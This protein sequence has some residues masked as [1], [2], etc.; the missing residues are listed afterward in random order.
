MID[1]KEC[2]PVDSCRIHTEK[3]AE[4]ECRAKMNSNSMNKKTAKYENWSMRYYKTV[5]KS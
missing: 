3:L 1:A 2:L 4:K 5:L